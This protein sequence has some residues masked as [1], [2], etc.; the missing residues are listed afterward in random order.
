M[1]ILPPV[2]RLHRVYTFTQLQV[3]CEHGD[4][5]LFFLSDI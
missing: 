3:I 4:A 2:K 1:T 5:F